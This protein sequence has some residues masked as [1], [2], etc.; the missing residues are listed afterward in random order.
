MTE[1][2]KTLANLRDRT[3]AM[4][5]CLGP[6]PGETECPCVI[7]RTRARE[8]QIPVRGHTMPDTKESWE[9]LAELYGKTISRQQ[10]QIE[11]LE[12]KNN[13]LR[14]KLKAKQPL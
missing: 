12:L 2:Q 11:R 14:Q 1:F 8:A 5:C 13:Q 3:E 6:Q 9:R 7:N 4:C 10:A